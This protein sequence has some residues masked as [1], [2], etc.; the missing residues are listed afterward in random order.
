MKEGIVTREIV[1]WT[2]DYKQ[3]NTT[4]VTLNTGETLYGS[5]NFEEVEKEINANGE[6]VIE[7]TEGYFIAISKV[8]LDVD[9]NSKLYAWSRTGDEDVTYYVYTLTDTPTTSDKAYYPNPDS[10]TDKIFQI[11]NSTISLIVSE[12]AITVEGQ[13]YTRAIAADISL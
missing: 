5:T 9:V 11:L 8:K 1:N 12:S 4:T 2:S 13:V 6:V 7:P 3:S 10:G